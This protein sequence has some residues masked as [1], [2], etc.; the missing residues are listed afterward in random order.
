MLKKINQ[1]NYK[2]DIERFINSKTNKIIEIKRKRNKIP[3]LF[4]RTK[5]QFI[6][7]DLKEKTTKIIIEGVQTI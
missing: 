4:I 2:I 1:K 3:Y 6:L 5:E 7:A